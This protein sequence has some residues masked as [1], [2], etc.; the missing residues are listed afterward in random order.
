VLVV[1]SGHADRRLDTAC[2]MLSADTVLMR[3]AAA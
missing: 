3:P 2:T 1:P